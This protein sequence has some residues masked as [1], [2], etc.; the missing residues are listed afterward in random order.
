MFRVVM[1][2]M[3]G[4]GGMG[5]PGIAGLPVTGVREQSYGIGSPPLHVERVLTYPTYYTYYTHVRVFP[6]LALTDYI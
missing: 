6:D 4:M 5:T 1:G 2:G 3:G